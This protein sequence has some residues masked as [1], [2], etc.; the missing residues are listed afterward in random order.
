LIAEGASGV[1]VPSACLTGG[2]NL[3]LWRW[4]DTSVRSLD[5]QAGLPR[6]QASWN[7]V[8]PSPPFR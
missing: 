1:L 3:A 8:A 5:P 2:T 4:N 6:D 7:P